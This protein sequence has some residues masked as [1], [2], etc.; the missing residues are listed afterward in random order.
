[1]TTPLGLAALTVLGTPPLAQLELAKRVGF[2]TIGIRL[3]PAAPGTTAYPIHL[4]A[5]VLDDFARRLAD[6]AV[7]VFDLEIIRIAPG[8][9][10]SA[11]L[12]L[13]EAGQRLGARAVLVGGDDPDWSRLTASYAAL[14]DLAAAHDMVASLEF[15]PWTAVPDARAAV[16]IVGQ[17]DGTGRSVLVDA[18]HVARSSTTPDDLA[19]IPTDWLHYAQMCDGTTPTPETDEELVHDAREHRLAPGDG[20]IDLIGIWKSLPAGLPVSIE[21]PNESERRRMGTAAWL[22][23]LV[24]STREVLSAAAAPR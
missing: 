14:A 6:S 12:P 15:M 2:D 13:F 19:A 5:R 7:S 21:V 3:L 22:R 9:E 4:E 17:A 23:R 24:L 1:M 11:Y 18:L 16:E 20:G 10:V 8:F